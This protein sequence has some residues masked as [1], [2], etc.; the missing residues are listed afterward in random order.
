MPI[1]FP[2]NPSLNSTHTVNGVVYKWDGDTWRSQGNTVV[3][4]MKAILDQIE[5][6]VNP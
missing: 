1:T 6:L 2:Q 4:E 3:A 5:A